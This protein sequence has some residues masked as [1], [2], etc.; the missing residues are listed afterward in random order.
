LTKKQADVENLDENETNGPKPTGVDTFHGSVYSLN[1]VND[2]LPF[3]QRNKFIKIT[4]SILKEMTD[5]K[6][7]FQ[8]WQ[9]L[10]ITLSNFFI[11]SGYFVPFMFITKIADDNK[12]DN[13][14]ILISIIGKRLQ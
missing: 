14:S 2:K 4:I 6:L 7:L 8:N 5:F 9:F 1:K 10:L 13:S 12:I 3:H 11:F